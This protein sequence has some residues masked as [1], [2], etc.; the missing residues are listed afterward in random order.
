MTPRDLVQSPVWKVMP[1]I[2]RCDGGE[3][4]ESSIL[5]DRGY[6]QF[7]IQHV[8]FEIAI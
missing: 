2:E 6:V 7:K 4:E 1:W 3:E 8:N 5:G